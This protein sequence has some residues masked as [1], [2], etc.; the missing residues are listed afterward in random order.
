MSD[1]KRKLMILGFDG[2]SPDLLTRWVDEGRLPV[3]AEIIKNGVF[4][5]LR[6]VT[7]M[8]SPPAWTS[9]ATGKNPGKHG[10][11]RFTER[12]FGSYRYTFVNGGFRRAETFWSMLCGDRTGC[13]IGVP[14]TFPVEKINGCMIAGFDAPAPESDGVC[15][16]KDLVSEV[17]AST[18]SYQLT[19]NLANL[20]RNGAHW[21]QAAQ[22]LLDNMQ[23]RF[24][25]VSYV[26]DKYDWDLFVTVFSETDLAHHF[27][28]KF[29]DPE[30]PDYNPEEAA[31]YGDTILHVYEKMDKIIGE[32]REKNPD[33]ALM[34]MSDHGGGINP[35]G[36]E[37]LA[38]WLDGVGL[39]VRE[40]SDWSSPVKKFRHGMNSFLGWSYRQTLKHLSSKT[41]FRLAGAFPWLRETVETTMKLGGIDWGKTKAFSDGAQ[42]DIWINLIGRDPMG[43]VS[44]SEY[45]QLC[46][47]I[48]AE[49]R[50]AVDVTTGKPIVDQVYRRKDIY[51]GNYI[52]RAPDIGVRWKTGAVINGIRTPHSREGLKPKQWTWPAEIN[53][54]AHSLDGIF[55]AEGEGLE[56]GL[57]LQGASI[58]DLAPTVMY[59]FG[60]EIPGD[61][62]G[63]LL[64]A[65]FKPERLAGEPPQYGAGTAA[66]TD[67][68]EQQVEHEQEDIYTEEDSSVI[69]QRLRDLGYL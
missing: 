60:E 54:G 66:P 46:E 15:H 21:D 18:G 48:C 53:T 17:S 65:V 42:D 34:I 56:Q 57:S 68:Q 19:P 69:E 29:I 32:F 1:D 12:V 14:M 27:F 2:V 5:P 49:L 22:K 61:M 67:G 8:Y 33:V 64:S 9:F 41:K 7:N 24:L 52:D 16:P 43:T 55:I 28:W 44:E 62:D 26:M 23:Q 51:S 3:I 50:E 35:R 45:E 38:D 36:E 31:R 10:I 47:Y 39:L 20:L 40:K 13:V 4:G 63:K 11:F 37:L 58:M 30:H 6:S 59:Y 25:N